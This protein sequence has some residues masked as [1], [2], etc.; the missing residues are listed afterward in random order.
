MRNIFW[1]KVAN[2]IQEFDDKNDARSLYAATKV[3]YGN[4]KK[5]SKRGDGSGGVGLYK[6][7]GSLAITEEEINQTWLEHCQLLFNQPSEVGDI[8]RYLG[9]S[10]VVNESL[11]RPFIIEELLVALLS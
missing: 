7:D 6:K 9:A 8:D 2:Y 11:V 5:E 1:L 3:I 4:K 10:K